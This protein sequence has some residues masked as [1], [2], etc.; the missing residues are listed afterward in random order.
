MRED[1][2]I[3]VDVR[4]SWENSA[5]KNQEDKVDVKFFDGNKERKTP[6]FKDIRSWLRKNNNS[7]FL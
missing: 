7:A 1:K 5:Y 4:R 2:K 3:F 6:N